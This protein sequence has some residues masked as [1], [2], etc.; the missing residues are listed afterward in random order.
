MFVSAWDSGRRE[1]PWRSLADPDRRLAI[2][3]DTDFGVSRQAQFF[4]WFRCQS[5]R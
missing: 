4:A 3:F 5:I 2:S 1:Y